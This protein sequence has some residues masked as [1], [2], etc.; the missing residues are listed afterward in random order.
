MA[1]INVR[2]LAG[3][4]PAALAIQQIDGRGL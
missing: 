4:D 3:S 2:C 1:A